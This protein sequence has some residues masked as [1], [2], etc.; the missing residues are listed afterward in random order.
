MQRP[1]LAYLIRVARARMHLVQHRRE[2]GLEEVVQ[3][4]GGEGQKGSPFSSDSWVIISRTR[5]RFSV[6]RSI[7]LDPPSIAI[8]P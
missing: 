4:G 7:R 1:R 8:N 6:L 3:V 5:L 2:D